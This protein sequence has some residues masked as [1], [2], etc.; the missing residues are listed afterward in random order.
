MFD[1]IIASF[2]KEFKVIVRERRLLA[3]IIVQPMILITIFG[4]AFSGELHKI[5]TVIVDDDMSV[6]SHQLVS[7]LASSE[8][9]EIK[10][11][12]AT[13]SEAIE[14]IKNGKASVAVHITENFGRDFLNGRGKI[15]V[16]VDESDFNVAT[17][18]K[19]YVQKVTAELSSELNGGIN[20]EQRYIFT[21]KTRLIDYVAPAIIGV[22][23]QVLGL[24]LSASS[25]AREKEEGTLELIL[26]TPMKSFDLIFGKFLCITTIITLDV[27]AVMFI[28]HYIFNV[29][30]RG[31]ILLLFIT[32]LLFLTGSIGLGL[33][34]ST[35]LTTQLQA[36]QLAMM[37]SVISIFLSGF[38]YPL[39][40]MPEYAQTIAYLIPLTYANIA[41]RSIMIK[42]C[43]L[44]VV[45]PQIAVLVLY[46][47]FTV[48][49]AVFLLRRRGLK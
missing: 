17:T 26:S 38:F 31:N 10:Y 23:I 7:A 4:Y 21:T 37:F 14:A 41:F 8:T 28:A 20:V 11:Y 22:I 32:Q 40:S 3:I 29:E 12:M 1:E 34:I 5:P 18:T 6:Q 39:E 47:V 16:I 19:N 13:T 15:E 44:E 9:L 43:G 2:E 33:A 49:L 27:I 36:V 35:A 45:Y 42:G 25:I 30:V 48:S 24:I 46:N